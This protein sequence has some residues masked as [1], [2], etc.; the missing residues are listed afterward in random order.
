MPAGADL[1]FRDSS[2]IEPERNGQVKKPLHGPVG[3][4]SLH[5]PQ[6]SR[7]LLK[8]LGEASHFTAYVGNFV[9]K[10]SIPLSFGKVR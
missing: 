5:F 2:R 1:L 3:V 6:P 8:R 9:I 4:A 10:I 7:H